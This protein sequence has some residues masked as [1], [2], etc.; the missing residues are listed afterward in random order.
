M[1]ASKRR[2]MFE[3]AAPAVA[4]MWP[5]HAGTYGCPLCGQFFAEDRFDALSVEHAPPRSLRGRK[6][7]AVL[8]CR[9]CN[10]RAGESVDDAMLDHEELR[11]LRRHTMT[12]RRESLVESAEGPVVMDV[13]FA[14]N[15]NVFLFGVPKASR[16]EA[17]DA[18]VREME[19]CTTGKELRISGTIRARRPQRW[20]EIGWLRSAYLI[21]FA[22]GGYRYAFAPSL[23]GV[24]AQLGP[25]NRDRV[26]IRN[27]AWRIR[28]AERSDAALRYIHEPELFRSIA[29][30]MG[31]VMVLLPMLDDMNLYSRLGDESTDLRTLNLRWLPIPWPVPPTYGMGSANRG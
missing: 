2:R 15:G 23:E 26:I 19:T 5:E 25:A 21:A 29:I 27:F 28:D 18:W 1:E 24:R 6:R 14:P 13:Q 3:A 12:R 17:H 7:V 31:D 10:S 30:Q 11:D 16:K 9:R 4:A 20:A 8:T 22:W